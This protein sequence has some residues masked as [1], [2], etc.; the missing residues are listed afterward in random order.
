MKN[1]KG[2][3]LIELMIVL[4][5]IAVLA[6]IALPSYAHYL[7]RKDLAQAQQEALNIASAL[8]K[9]RSKNFNYK[10]FKL[11]DYYG[12]NYDSTNNAIYLPLGSTSTTAKYIFTLVAD[13]TTK[14]ALDATDTAITGKSWV[15]KIERAK[16]GS[17]VKQ[18]NN[19]DLLLNNSGM[20][21]M[22][23]TPDIVKDYIDCG[24]INV[25]SW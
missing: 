22:T 24:A 11:A 5:I 7:E 9:F 21:C 16:N 17:V 25:E 8:D 13:S 12:A 15:L 19:Y 3:T 1:K 2:F 10:G 6:A 23:K 18:P 14:K 4:M 20:R